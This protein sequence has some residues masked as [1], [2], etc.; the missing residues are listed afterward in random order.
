MVL[1]IQLSWI[2][3]FVDDAECHMICHRYASNRCILQRI[4][5]ED[6]KRLKSWKIPDSALISCSS[7]ESPKF[8]S[9][10]ETQIPLARILRIG[11]GQAYRIK[12]TYR[13]LCRRR[14]ESLS[15]GDQIQKS[16][17]Q[18]V[19]HFSGSLKRGIACSSSSGLSQK[20]R[21]LEI[22]DCMMALPRR[23]TLGM[24]TPR[25]VIFDHH[26]VLSTSL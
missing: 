6:E 20:V 7:F 21:T 24:F 25:G 4:L 16:L 23:L 10:K 12:D 9:F 5:D 22:A 19:W 15:D 17:L 8:R 1:E 18:D 14:V 11:S 3:G 2:S 13:L 26:R